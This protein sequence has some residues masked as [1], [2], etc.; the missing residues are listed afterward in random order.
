MSPGELRQMT[1][2][3]NFLAARA[4]IAT[5][6]LAASLLSLGTTSVRAQWLFNWD[7]GL[8]PMQVERMVSASGYRLTGPVARNGSVYL[9]NVLGRENDSERLVIDARSG[10]LLERFRAARRPQYAMAGASAGD[11]S[12]PPP[13]RASFFDGWSDRDDDSLAPRPPANVYGDS[14]PGMVHVPLAPSAPQVHASQNGQI[15][16][17]EDS[18]GASPYVIPAPSAAGPAPALEKPKAK[19]VVKHRKP[20]PAPLADRPP[21]PANPQSATAPKAAPTQPQGA[22]QSAPAAPR[23]AAETKPVAAAAPVIPAASPAPQPKA[24]KPKPVL[25]DVPVAPLE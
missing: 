6:A 10:R 1:I 22:S 4:Q 7:Q 18:N 5:L 11:W 15:A 13:P 21:A 19:V 3:S 14:G 16:R 12:S 20:E 8:S 24:D 2:R 23:V 25:N 9:A 17:A